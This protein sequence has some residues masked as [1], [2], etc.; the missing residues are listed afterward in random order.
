MDLTLRLESHREAAHLFGSRDRNLR[1]LRERL[2][3]AVHAR[4]GTLR[5]EGETGAVETASRCLGRALDRIRSGEE[6]A[7]EAFER[8][9]ELEARA[10]DPAR[11][12]VAS[13]LAPALEG[14]RVRSAGQ[15]S[16][17]E[18]ILSHELSFAIGPAGTGKTFLAVAMAVRALREGEV[19]RI[20]LV[21]P[22]VEAGEK[23]GFLPGDIQAKVNPYLRPLYD[24][25]NELLDY[26]Q[27]RRYLEREIIEIV[28][29]AY[30]RG[31]TLNRAFII[32]DEAQNT[33]PTQMLMFLTRMG[34]ASR[35]VVTGDLTQVDLPKGQKS[36][37]RHAQRLLGRVPG[38]AFVTLSK[39]DIV[40]HPLVTQIVEAY[41]RG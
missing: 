24:A 37:L 38:I 1:L 22:A 3:V 13:V 4:N 15:A 7:P 19:R 31:R 33:T 40:R 8:L 9:L 5:I 32:L 6:L 23:L 34:E 41:E 18:T 28:P 11:A 21:R 30:M 25:L 29:L 16:Y 17:V 12:A 10:P 2:G 36:G 35:I 20:C 39:A 14:L 27:V 26:D